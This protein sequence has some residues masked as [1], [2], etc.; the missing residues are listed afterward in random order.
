M[1]EEHLDKIFELQ[2]QV[3]GTLPS[4]SLTSATYSWG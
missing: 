4:S 2:E 3:R 1:A